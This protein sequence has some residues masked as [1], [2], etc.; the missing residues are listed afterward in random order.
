MLI[1]SCKGVVVT[2]GRVAENTMNNLYLFFF[3][4]FMYSSIITV[5]MIMNQQK[6]I[7][8]GNFKGRKNS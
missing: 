8:V 1:R 7:Q 5:K 3:R 4:N 2:G 6:T